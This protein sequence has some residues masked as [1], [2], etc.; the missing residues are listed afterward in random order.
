M[1]PFSLTICSGGFP[2]AY[3]SGKISRATFRLMVPLS[4]SLSRL[5]RRSGLTGD[6]STAVPLRFSSASNSPIT[7]LLTV[8]G[9][10]NNLMQLSK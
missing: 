6:R 2:L 3:S 8:F 1:R 10:L 9:W 5:T 7:Q 4:T